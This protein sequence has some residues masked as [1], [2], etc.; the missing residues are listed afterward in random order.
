MNTILEM[1]IGLRRPRLLQAATCIGYSA[2]LAGLMLAFVLMLPSHLN[3]QGT[4]GTITGAVTDP[5]GAAVQ[6]A[7][8]TIRNLDTNAVSVVSSSEVGGYKVTHLS[9]G[10]YSVKVDKANYKS[11]QQKEIVLQMDQVAQI[12]ASLQIGSQQ[13]TIE[14]T[15]AAPTIQTEASSIGLVIESQSI[16][17]TPL[18]GRLSVMGLIAISPGVQAVGAQDQLADRGMTPAIGSGGRN[19]YG[20]FGAT[21]DG[22]VNQEVALAR[23]AP[24]IPP[25]GAI[26]QFKMVS[27][28]APAEFGEQAQ[29]IVVSKSGANQYHGEALEF[30]RSKGT[31]AKQYFSGSLVR[32]AYERNEFGGVLSGPLTIPHLYKGTDRSFFLFAFEGFRLNQATSF[33]TQQPTE[34]MRTGDFSEFLAGGACAG[35]TPVTIVNPISGGP[36]IVNN[37]IPTS[38]QNSVDLKL[39]S[40]FYPHPTTTGCGVNTIEQANYVS[41][42]KRYSLRV[43]HKISEKNQ[44][45]FTF[46]RA[47]YGPYPDSGYDSLQGGNSADGEIDTLFVLGYTHVFSPSLL[48]D[49]YGS[50]NHLPIYRTPQNWKVDMASI[51]PGLGTQVINGAPNAISITN[52]QSVSEGGSKGFEQDI[53]FYSS[54]TKVM[55]KHTIKAGVGYLYNNYWSAGASSPQRGTYS[56]TGRYSGNAFA[57]FIMG[58]PNS[59]GNATPSGIVGRVLSS[60]YSG[61]VQD[62]WKV[63]PKLT[64]NAGIRYDMQWFNQSP[65]GQQA[66]YI[67]SLKSIVVFGDSLKGALS[68]FTNGSIPITTSAAAGITSNP[69]SYVGRQPHNFAPRLGFA[70][71][72]I[73]NT[74]LRGAAGLYFNMMPPGYMNNSFGGAPFTATPTYSQPA[75]NVPSITMNAPFS[76]TGAYAANYGV[77]AEHQLV[78]P[79]SFQYNLAIERQFAKGI[80]IRLGYVGQHNMKQN[81]TGG[82]GNIVPNINLANPPLLGSTVQST[83]LVQP[84]SSI[85]LNNSPLFHSL[86]NE[87]QFG[88]HKRY[89]NGLSLNAEYQWTRVIGTE[90][91]EN[92]SGQAPRDSYGPLAGI[93]PQVLQVNYSYALPMGKNKLL[94]ASAGAFV[95]KIVSGWQV[96]GT[97]N[98]QTGQ[99]FSVSYTAPGSNPIGQVSGRANRT[100]GVALYPA[101][102][103]KA[104]WFNKDAF[105]APPCYNSVLTGS[106]TVNC[107]AVYTAGQTAGVPSYATYGTSGYQMLRGPGW[108]NWDMNL[109]KTTTWKE[110]YRLEMRADSF[111]IFNHPNLGNPAANISNTSTV[112]TITSTASSPSYQARTVEFGVKFMF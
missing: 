13:E 81:N 63:S 27:S 56:F 17:N 85:G 93:T 28:G 33:S 74:V 6:G 91:M 89:S 21:Y 20:G 96:S 16:Q 82:S 71:Q 23:A 98:F 86:L 64:V 55:S 51:I 11:F 68:N 48:L 18:N 26:G 102:K 7:T 38:M 112:G 111:N 70:Y 1:P 99:P 36:A 30:N 76:A 78:T 8:V 45:R 108:Q 5:S 40:L 53:Q 15:T 49:A 50:Y 66:L 29:L 24:E 41:A 25:F 83:N 110:R 43:D 57:D 88:L 75:G 105:Y 58:Y 42:A 37:Q 97:T 84:F 77:S 19:A 106:A 47:E 14:V 60:H 44:L 4:T 34:K 87:L 39:L 69:M 9:P 80:D 32:P 67:P 35:A 59:T 54:L 31:S 109:Q 100:P 72:V 94:F 92:P 104:Q 90:N 73:P 101:K 12:N 10:R 103:T 65:Y 61:Y 52:I 46:L 22:V 3:A 95:D 107:L 62:D 79:R 2:L